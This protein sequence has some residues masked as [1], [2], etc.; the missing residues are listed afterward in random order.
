ME[1]QIFLQTPSLVEYNNKKFVI[2]AYPSNNS[3]QNYIDFL[4][5]HDIK[6][7]VKT[8][9]VEYN[10][11]LFLKNGITIHYLIFRDGGIPSKKIIK[12][13]NNLVE[14]SEG[15]IGVHCL[16]GLGRAPTLVVLSL[17][18]LGM[19]SLDAVA[20]V[21]KIRRGAI[22]KNQLVFLNKYK[23]SRCFI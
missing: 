4:K 15:K 23:N 20:Y 9:D 11:E 3:I 17:I 22:N 5:K 8:C 7:L 10:E 21:R 2:F 16:S 18:N 12:K 1:C 6:H 14:L 13:W 19:D